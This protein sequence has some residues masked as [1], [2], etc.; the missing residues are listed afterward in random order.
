MKPSRN[1]TRELLDERGTP[2]LYIK[3]IVKSDYFVSCVSFQTGTNNISAVIT[4]TIHGHQWKGICLNPK[5]Q[6]MY[7][8]DKE[9]GLDPLLFE[10]IGQSSL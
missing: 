9:H 1:D 5:Q 6:I 2:A 10:M 4:T 8:H 7:E 3:E